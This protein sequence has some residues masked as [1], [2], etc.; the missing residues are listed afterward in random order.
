M[1]TTLRTAERFSFTRAM[2]FLA[3][4]T[5]HLPRRSINK[6][7]SPN[8]RPTQNGL[9]FEA[10]TKFKKGKG[11]AELVRVYEKI[12][13]G[14]WAF[15]GFF[16]L[17]DSWTETSGSRS[18]FK[19]KLAVTTEAPAEVPGMV[20]DLPQNRLIPT[21]VKLAVWKRD[22]GRCVQCGS[23]DNVH[24]DHIIPFSLGGSSLVAENIQ[25][26]CARHNL[27]KHDRIT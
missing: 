21:D 18:V 14:I 27:Q 9:F 23:R 11:P 5:D 12:R 1:P 13:D 17:V 10:A 22:G 6:R 16:L 26:L 4:K 7:T 20:G 2:T 24:F 25:L 3:S 15:D 8:G 19:F